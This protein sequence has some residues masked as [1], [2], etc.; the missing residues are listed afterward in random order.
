MNHTLSRRPPVVARAPNPST[1]L[2]AVT[3]AALL[4]PTVFPAAADAATKYRMVDGD[5]M[6]YVGL[7]F[8]V[9][10]AAAALLLSSRFL[11]SFNPALV[12]KA[13]ISRRPLAVRAML[14]LDHVLDPVQ[15]MFGM[16]EQED[17]NHA[18]VFFLALLSIVLEILFGDS[19]LLNESIPNTDIVQTL[20]YMIYFINTIALPQWAMLVFRFYKLI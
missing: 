20:H 1:A 19:G 9:Y 2:P 3:A 13:R 12:K 16:T 4:L 11:L 14:L 18:S 5:T 10:S 17:I 15:E 8:A 7:A 6:C